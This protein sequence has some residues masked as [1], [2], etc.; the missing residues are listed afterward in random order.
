MIGMLPLLPVVSANAVGIFAFEPTFVTK[1]KH[2][3]IKIYTARI[4]VS[5]K[6]ILVWKN[7]KATY[8]N[9]FFSASLFYTPMQFCILFYNQARIL[10]FSILYKKCLFPDS[11]RSATYTVDSRIIGPPEF[12][13]I[14]TN[15]KQVSQY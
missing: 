9:A 6:N 1:L 4:L 7:C 5:L 15:S 2:Y 8:T 14:R 12:S 10:L 3:K 13:P 11:L